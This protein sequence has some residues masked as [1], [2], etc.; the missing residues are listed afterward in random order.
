MITLL[1]IVKEF[2][3]PSAAS[4]PDGIAAGVDG[5][6]WFAESGQAQIGRIHP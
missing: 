4:R 5:A 2:G 6:L 3:I 1:G